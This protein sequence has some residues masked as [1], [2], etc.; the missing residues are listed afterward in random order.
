MNSLKS[1]IS[2]GILVAVIAHGLTGISLV[3]DKV[4][5]RRRET[6]NLL[7]YVFW[8]GAISVFGL[9]LIPFGFKMPGLRL[10]GM[11]F[12]AG[13]LDLISCFFYYSV[14]EIWRSIRGTCRHGRLR[15]R[16]NGPDFHSI[17]Y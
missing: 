4:L 15:A 10:A 6:Q 13:L 2:N 17:T 11:A 8:L 9:A 3:W 1:V 12:T 16:S 7:S 14:R 5:L